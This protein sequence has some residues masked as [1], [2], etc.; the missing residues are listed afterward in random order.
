MFADAIGA[1]FRQF[2]ER[3]HEGKPARV[4]RAVRGY[5][6][7]PANLWDAVTNRERLPRWFMPIEGELRLGGRYQLEG[8]AGGSIT[9]CEPPEALDVTWEFMGGMSWVTVRLEPEGEGTRLTLEHIVQA[10]DVDEH[11]KQYGPGAAGVGWELSLLGLGLHIA[12]G[13]E[14]VELEA[15]EGWTTSDEGKAFMR[16]SAEAWARA[17][18]AGGEEP[19]TARGMAERTAAFYTGG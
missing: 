12:S 14:T 13:G 5:R 1:E 18:I 15:V 7:H 17:H 2:L 9:R 3:E 8:N 19:A 10:S 16:A 4:L 6:T 11:W